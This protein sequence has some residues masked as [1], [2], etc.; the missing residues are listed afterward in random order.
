MTAMS[1]GC[2]NA[3]AAV[4]DSLS[5]GACVDENAALKLIIEDS[6]KYS[7]RKNPLA[8]RDGGPVKRSSRK[9]DRLISSARIDR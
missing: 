3:C 5:I 7:L 2:D 1:A 6:A 9:S 8:K 4:A